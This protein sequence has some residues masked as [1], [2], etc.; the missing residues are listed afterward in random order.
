LHASLVYS[1]Y[2]AISLATGITTMSE[3]DIG[4]Q[5]PTP[6][7]EGGQDAGEQSRP[8][9]EE[10]DSPPSAA[11]SPK[12]VDNDD[13]PSDNES[14]L[15][16]VDEGEFA[17]FDPTTVALEDRPLVDIDEDIARTLKAGKR[18]KTGEGEGKKVKEGK[19]E[20]KKKRA[21]DE[22]EDPDGQQIE[23]K[24]IRKPKS[25]RIEGD[26][27]DRERARERKA[28]TPENDENLTPE[29]RRRRA[30]DKAMDAALKNPNKRRRKKD[31]VVG[32]TFLPCHFDSDCL[33]G[34]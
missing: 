4:S 21:R 19:R 31:E 26:R 18:K 25:V 6:L 2:I 33:A 12:D 10:Q 11:Q 3:S 20:K 8:A 30:L 9:T 27:N 17:D 29:E 7:P 5:P 13:D 15:S 14:E 24:R 16:E 32:S 1:H 28:P 34:P 23:G 22:D